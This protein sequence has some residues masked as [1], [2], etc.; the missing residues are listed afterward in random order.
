MRLTF[1]T[2]AGIKSKKHLIHGSSRLWIL[3]FSRN[4]LLKEESYHS[5]LR[6][7][8]GSLEVYHFTHGRARV[9]LP[10]AAIPLPPIHTQ[11]ITYLPRRHACNT[12]HA[13]RH[14][15]MSTSK[16]WQQ[17][18]IYYRNSSAGQNAGASL[19]AINIVIFY[20]IWHW[21]QSTLLLRVMYAWAA[22]HM[23]YWFNWPFQPLQGHAFGLLFHFTSAASH[24]ANLP[25]R[26]LMI[27]F[28]STS[29]CATDSH[30]SL[31]IPV[32]AKSSIWY[33]SMIAGYASSLYWWFR[34]LWLSSSLARP[35]GC[36]FGMI[37]SWR[38]Y[39]SKMYFSPHFL[40]FW[41]PIDILRYHSS[42]LVTPH[43]WYAFSD[44]QARATK[45]QQP[46]PASTTS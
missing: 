18:M 1:I 27:S 28:I 5:L 40:Y 38:Y 22:G 14:H 8:I 21:P 34:Q 44:G 45:A 15:A 7:I 43:Y 41:L 6:L 16:N 24:P 3:L 29:D 31:T 25:Y 33:W 26:F 19:L 13:T 9:K 23:I 11:V 37:D 20:S 42:R 2:L 35:K 39:N 30:W 12:R 10:I 4:T 46:F 32:I 17:Y 36:C